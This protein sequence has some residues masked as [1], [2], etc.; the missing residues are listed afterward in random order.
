M[1]IL[2]QMMDPSDGAEVAAVHGPK[3]QPADFTSTSS[4][5]RYRHYPP[6][7]HHYMNHHHHRHHPPATNP[8]PL[9]LPPFSVLIFDAHVCELIADS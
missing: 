6:T 4:P 5:H 7:Q 1:K 2:D 3:L 8:L 9:L